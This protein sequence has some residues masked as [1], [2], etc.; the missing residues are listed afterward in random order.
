[1][2]WQPIRTQESRQ[3]TQ[4]YFK[5]T[6]TINCSTV[7][8]LVVPY[9]H[10]Q[11]RPSNHHSKKTAAIVVHHIEPLPNAVSGEPLLGR[12]RDGSLGDGLPAS[13]LAVVMGIVVNVCKVVTPTRTHR[14]RHRRGGMRL[15]QERNAHT[16]TKCNM[17]TFTAHSLYI[18]HLR[19]LLLFR[20]HITI[21][22]CML[23]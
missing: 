8:G 9:I 18:L 11:P 19:G 3:R 5:S 21:H 17:Y 4:S 16:H 10:F 6:C 7:Q 13:S 14:A 15:Q 1:M 22:A 23:L 12:V 2:G 20:N